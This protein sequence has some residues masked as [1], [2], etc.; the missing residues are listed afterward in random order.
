[1]ICDNLEIWNILSHYKQIK[2]KY[3]IKFNI[4][5]NIFVYIKHI[6]ISLI[7]IIKASREISLCKWR[8]YTV[9]TYI[10]SL[11]DLQSLF[12]MKKKKKIYQMLLLPKQRRSGDS[13]LHSSLRVKLFDVVL[14]RLRRFCRGPVSSP[15]VGSARSWIERLVRNQRTDRLFL[16]RRDQRD[17]V[18]WRL[19]L[20][21]VLSSKVTGKSYSQLMQ[22]ASKMS[23]SYSSSVFKDIKII[24]VIISG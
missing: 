2:I 20:L 11:C 4:K 21:A 14:N 17:L 9:F 19:Y 15:V 23:F 22:L 1:M 10:I 5:N 6:L 16:L 13:Y 3:Q 8:Y 18:E 24:V 12:S 7:N